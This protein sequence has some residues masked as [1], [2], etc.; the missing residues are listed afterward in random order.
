VRFAIAVVLFFVAVFGVAASRRELIKHH[1]HP[2]PYKP[3]S[4]IVTSG[5]YRRTRNPIYIAFM[6]V[7]LAAAVAAN[8]VWLLLSIVVLFV[9]LEFGVVRAEER[10]LSG[11]FGAEY[12]EYRQRVRRW[13]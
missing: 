7:V 13:L 6:I 10:Y 9:L 3:T 8:S 1:E 5:V 2:N 11:K 4:A 12:D